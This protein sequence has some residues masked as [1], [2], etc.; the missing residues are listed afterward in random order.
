MRAAKTRGNTTA[1]PLRAEGDTGNEA[2]IFPATGC[3]VA[4]DQ[5]V[6]ESMQ[7]RLDVAFNTGYTPEPRDYVLRAQQEIAAMAKYSPPPL[8]W[9][10]S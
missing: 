4:D 1:S 6:I 7:N 10:R 9:G 5:H 2:G 8:M 3:H